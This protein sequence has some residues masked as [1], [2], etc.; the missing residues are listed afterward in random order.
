MFFNIQHANCEKLWMI[1]T[2]G[3]PRKH[4][5]RRICV[6]GIHGHYFE[7]CS[8]QGSQFQR[9]L[10]AE[11]NKIE[12][13]ATGSKFTSKKNGYLITFTSERQKKHLLD[14]VCIQFAMRNIK[15]YIS[16]K[17][18]QRQRLC[19]GQ[20]TMKQV[21]MDTNANLENIS[22]RILILKTL[23]QSQKRRS[24]KTVF[25]EKSKT[26]QKVR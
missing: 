23:Y 11:R 12:S 25:Y 10:E 17:S 5:R 22:P 8:N 3:T 19:E 24:G 7:H 26:H 4:P 15:P 9:D 1:E 20:D 21:Q 6:C 16:Y 18:R 13:M 14:R 2:K